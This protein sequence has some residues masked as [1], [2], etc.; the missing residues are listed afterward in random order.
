[1]GNHSAKLTWTV[2]AAAL[3]A[4]VAVVPASSP[5]IRAK[6]ENLIGTV[7]TCL[8]GRG[9]YLRSEARLIAVLVARIV[10]LFRHTL[11]GHLHLLLVGAHVR[12]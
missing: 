4:F 2:T 3:A 7:Q 8:W 9:R 11:S 1:M 5:I 10:P 6:T 12:M